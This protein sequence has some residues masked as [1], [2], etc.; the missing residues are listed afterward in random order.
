[1][2]FKCRRSE[3]GCGCGVPSGVEWSLDGPY[4]GFAA[5]SSVFWIP[6]SHCRL[7]EAKKEPWTALLPL[8]LACLSRAGMAWNRVEQGHIRET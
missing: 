2:S 7:L 1:M 3:Y 5:G 8:L 6:R 4:P